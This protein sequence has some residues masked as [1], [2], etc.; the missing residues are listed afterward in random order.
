MME[1]DEEYFADWKNMIAGAIFIGGTTAV[2]VYAIASGA[3]DNAFEI[4]SSAGESVDPIVTTET[5]YEVPYT[6]PK[7]PKL[8]DV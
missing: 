1:Q 2:A 6:P 3:L 5:I 7:T 8:I 4:L